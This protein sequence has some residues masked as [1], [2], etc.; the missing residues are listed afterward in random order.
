MLTSDGRTTENQ[1]SNQF[2]CLSV[3]CLLRRETSSQ[4]FAAHWRNEAL[5]T[6]AALFQMFCLGVLELPQ[7]LLSNK[8]ES[9]PSNSVLSKVI[10]VPCF[11]DEVEERE[12]DVNDGGIPNQLGFRSL[13]GAV[14]ICLEIDGR[15]VDADSNEGCDV[16]TISTKRANARWKR[17]TSIPPAIKPERLTSTRRPSS[18]P[19]RWLYCTPTGMTASSIWI[20]PV[21]LF[22]TATRPRSSTPI[23]PR[24]FGYKD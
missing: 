2:L 9:P 20:V 1:S 4:V 24:P 17:P 14:A 8:G 15:A 19:S 11:G 12:I 6:L 13:V 23:L 21:R 7:F 22:E 16:P 18:L 3:C 5:K 10:D